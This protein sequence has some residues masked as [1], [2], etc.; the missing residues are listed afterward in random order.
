VEILEKKGIR[1]CNGSRQ[2]RVEP[3]AAGVNC[4]PRAAAAAPE[5]GE[6]RR[7]ATKR[8]RRR[9][10]SVD[11]GRGEEDRGGKRKLILHRRESAGHVARGTP[12]SRAP[13]A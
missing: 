4:T 12:M 8:N 2:G 3:R 6:A 11:R 7:E 13:S 1:D 5:E 10:G 9:G